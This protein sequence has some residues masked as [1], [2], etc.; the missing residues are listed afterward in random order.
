MQNGVESDMQYATVLGLTLASALALVLN[1]AP[2]RAEDVTGQAKKFN[3]TY[4]IVSGKSHGKDVSDEHLNG[5]VVIKDDTMTTYD[6][7]HK[8]VYVI[9]YALDGKGD[10]AET[11]LMTVTKASRPEAVGMKAWGLIKA[12]GKKLMLVYDYK[13]KTYPTDFSATGDGQNMFVL[14]RVSEK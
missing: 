2:S 1:V 5:K 6:K 10:Q 12:D 7:E 9:R 4:T 14:E 3:G 13:G 8:E 11:L